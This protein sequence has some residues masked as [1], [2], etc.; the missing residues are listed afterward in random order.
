[1]DSSAL[2]PTIFNIQAFEKDETKASVSDEEKHLYSLSKQK[3][4]EIITAFKKRVV[5]ELEEVNKGLMA[6]GH[7]FEEI[8]K[9]AVIINLA[10]SIVDRIFNMVSDAKEA[11]EA[12]I[13][14]K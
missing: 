2:K 11:C 6:S 5:E 7:N 4:W 14:G 9:N 13:N 10:E 3:G 1:M 12:D 8:G